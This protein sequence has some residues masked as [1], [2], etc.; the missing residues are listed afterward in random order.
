MVLCPG[1]TIDFPSSF[2]VQ[3]DTRRAFH[4]RTL[5]GVPAHALQLGNISDASSFIY[6]IGQKPEPFGR[7][8]KFFS[9]GSLEVA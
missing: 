1:R 8:A 3:F 6:R 5:T 7:H 9:P 4:K 2:G